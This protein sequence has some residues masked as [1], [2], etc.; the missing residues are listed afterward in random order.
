MKH[1]TAFL[2]IAC[3]LTSVTSLA[4]QITYS[5]KHVTIGDLRRV[6]EKQA[7][8]TIFNSNS[9][10]SQIKPVN[11]HIVNGTLE[12]LLDEYFRYQTCTYTIIDKTITVIPRVGHK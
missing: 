10:S 7:G 1:I 4:Q 2:I 11:I 9:I 3:M 6:L 12:Q 5:K 8:Y